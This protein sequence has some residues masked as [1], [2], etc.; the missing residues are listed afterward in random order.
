MSIKGV[1]G[2]GKGQFKKGNYKFG[3]AVWTNNP[4]V[5]LVAGRT[6]F[7]DNSDASV[8]HFRGASWQSELSRFS[9]RLSPE[10]RTQCY[11]AAYDEEG[12]WHPWLARPLDEVVAEISTDWFPA[13]LGG[14]G[15]TSF[16][17][18]IFCL[19]DM[20]VHGYEA[21]ARACISGKVISGAELFSAADSHQAA[22]RLDAAARV[23]AVNVGSAQLNPDQNLFINVIPGLMD[24]DSA[25]MPEL[26]QVAEQADMCPSRIVIEFVESHKVSNHESLDVLITTIREH[27][28][29][30]AVDD[31]GVGYNSLHLIEHIMPDIV[32]FDRSLLHKQTNAEKEN[33]VGSLVRYCQ[34]LD[35]RTVAEGVET[36]EHLAFVQSCGFDMVQG[37]LIG[38]PSAEALRVDHSV[39]LS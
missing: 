6:A 39:W 37:W 5:A 27:G 14:T 23:A 31:F 29:M 34:S 18:P 15:L 10:D 7:S 2:D 38:K 22:T 12:V 20:K 33:V 32:K 11:V 19:N 35:I 25:K 1:L 9:S 13:I 26:W 24:S 4:N 30:I 17:Q 36:M 28:A 16:L 3:A 21:L 8:F